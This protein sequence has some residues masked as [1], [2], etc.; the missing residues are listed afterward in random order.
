MN[1]DQIEREVS[2]LRTPRITLADRLTHAAKADPC[3]KWLKV[4]GYDV[5]YVQR[6][7]LNS[8]PRIIIRAE[9]L[10]DQ[11]EGAVHRFERVGKVESRY[12]VAIRFDCEVRWY[13][14][15]PVNWPGVEI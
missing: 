3:V 11:L 2:P 4:Q 12:R 10:C 7:I 1:W 6:G 5:L 13:E 9:P 14:A 15:S 8:P